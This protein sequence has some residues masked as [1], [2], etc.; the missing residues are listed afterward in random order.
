[1]TLPYRIFLQ[2]DPANEGGDLDD[3]SDVTWCRDRINDSDVAYLREADCVGLLYLISEIRDAVGDKEG[4]LMQQELVARCRYLANAEQ[5][6]SGRQ[7]VEKG[8]EA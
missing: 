1:M 6:R 2:V 7:L 8:G 3:F 4:K 5:D